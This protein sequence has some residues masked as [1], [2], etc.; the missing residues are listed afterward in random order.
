[1][2]LRI[3]IFIPLAL[4]FAMPLAFAVAFSR[5][6][7]LFFIERSKNKNLVQYDVRLTE[8]N[9]IAERDPVAVYWILEN[10][11]QRNLTSIQRTLAYGIDSYKRIDKNKFR[12]ALV[13][14]KEREVIVERIEGFFRAVT[15]INGEPSVLEK[16]Y[17]TSRE[18]LFGLP[19][20]LYIDL[21][22]RSRE[23]G[24]PTNERIVA[25]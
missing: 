6:D 14:L 3:L 15:L 11:A 23:T 7:H 9:D 1:M 13:A 22:G 21:F 12:V 2:K 19:K 24:S 16:I 18:N 10:G 20:V 5:A 17:V 4:S 8:N 25:G